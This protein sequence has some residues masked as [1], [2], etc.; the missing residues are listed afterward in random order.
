MKVLKQSSIEEGDTKVHT[1]GLLWISNQSHNVDLAA[2]SAA[3]AELPKAEPTVET[4]LFFLRGWGAWNHIPAQ[5]SG[6]WAHSESWLLGSFP[7]C[8]PGRASIVGP[9]IMLGQRSVMV[10]KR[11]PPHLTALG[12]Q[13]MMREGGC[14]AGSPRR[15]TQAGLCSTPRGKCAI[16]VRWRL[17]F[18]SLSEHKR[19]L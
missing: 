13:A 10:M 14:C 8:C 17:G 2:P 1:S 16:A 15:D 12:L 7:K 19:D 6:Q 18:S 11:A 9:G 4:K 3:S 5:T